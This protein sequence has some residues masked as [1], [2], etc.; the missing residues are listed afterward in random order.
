[1]TIHFLRTEQNLRWLSS[2]SAPT[3]GTWKRGERVY[4][5]LPTANGVDGWICVVA[6]T[7]GTW[8]SF[9]TIQT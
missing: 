9:G 3:T 7:P 1:M 4:N 5:T 6:G 8:K 2:N